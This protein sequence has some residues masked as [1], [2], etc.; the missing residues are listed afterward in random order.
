MQHLHRLRAGFSQETRARL[1]KGGPG[2]GGPF[3]WSTEGQLP[4]AKADGGAGAQP[5]LLFCK[6]LPSQ[7]CPQGQPPSAGSTWGSLG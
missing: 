7:K 4:M 3:I 1:Q 6:G 2:P 5:S